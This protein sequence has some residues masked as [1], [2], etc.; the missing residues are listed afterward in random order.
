MNE[1]KANNKGLLVV[2]FGTTHTDTCEETIGAIEEHLAKAISSRR[3]YRAWTSRFIIKKLKERDGIVIDTVSEALDRM[4]SDGIDDILVVPTHML[5][6]A[7]Y[8]KVMAAVA[9]AGAS[10]SREQ[11]SDTEAEH[12]ERKTETEYR[13]EKLAVS[14]PLLDTEADLKRIAEV[15]ADELLASN[16][17]TALGDGISSPRRDDTDLSGSTTNAKS[18]AL[19]LMGHGSADKPEINRVYLRLEEEFHSAGHDNVFVGTVEGRP[20]IDDVIEKF[21]VWREAL[22]ETAVS[23]PETDI[24]VILAPLMIVAGDHAINDMA[25][26]DP[27]SWKN[28]IAAAMEA[29][30]VIPVIRGLG[31]YKGV[32][33]MFAGHAEQAML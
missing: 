33:D 9:Q 23:E 8:D 17:D 22:K 19:V 30:E 28:R 14:R 20:S 5:P 4:A 12:E 10:C 11:T 7:E 1:T 29:V 15:L 18:T 27:N 24:A 13:F 21:K 25:G 26:D 32:R 3:F 16:D 6:G 2:S 31:S